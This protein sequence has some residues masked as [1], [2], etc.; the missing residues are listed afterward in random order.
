MKAVTNILLALVFLSIN[1]FSQDID[2]IKF[3]KKINQLRSGLGLSELQ[4]DATL[5][6]VAQAWVN[7]MLEAFNEYTD[8]EIKSNYSNDMHF[9]HINF[10]Q[11]VKSVRS[12]KQKMFEGKFISEIAIMG[13]KDSFFDDTANDSFNGW[14]RSKPH[15]KAMIK[16]RVRSFGFAHF[17]DKKNGRSLYLCVFSGPSK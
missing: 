14:M 12:V 8:A 3:A 13:I 10:D 7:E 5:D 4:W 15:Y 16:D 11:R 17:N 1:A 9:I 2:D 6:S